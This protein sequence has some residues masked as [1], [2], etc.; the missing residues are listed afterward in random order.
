MKNVITANPLAF[1]A[2]VLANLSLDEL[3]SW[4]PGVSIPLI[5]ERLERLHEIGQGL[6]D[7]YDGHAVNMVKASNNSCVKLVELILKSFPGFRDTTIYEGKLIHL[8]KRAQ[9]L[10]GDIWAAYGKSV[11]STKYYYFSDLDQLTMFADY[12]IP[13][14]LRQFNVLQY[15]VDLEQQIDAKIEIAFGSP[16]ETEIR[17]CTVEAVER[18]HAELKKKGKSLYVI[19]LDWLLWQLGE[20]SMH[21]CAPHHRTLTIY[22]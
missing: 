6:L 12:R 9:I 19:E 1:S 13:Q 21:S 5:D 18:L 10:T 17:A 8:Y 14:I 2:E 11:D 22:Y 3:T 16:A 4:F 20:S 7:G 15:S